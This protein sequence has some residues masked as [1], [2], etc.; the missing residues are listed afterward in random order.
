MN[1]EQLLAEVDELIAHA[2]ILNAKANELK[3]LANKEDSNIILVPDNIKISK[4]PSIHNWK[5]KLY[6]ALWFWSWVVWSWV[7]DISTQYKLIPCKYEDLKEW[8]IFYRDSDSTPI[9]YFKDLVWYWI[10]LKEWYQYWN[11]KDCKFWEIVFTYNW[12]VLPIN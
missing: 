7:W 3:E 5:H 9:N 12:K 4:W 1:K 8:D 6:Y 2:N 10:K 11:D